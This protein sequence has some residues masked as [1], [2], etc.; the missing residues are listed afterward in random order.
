MATAAPS[1]A[2]GAAVPDA[3]QTPSARRRL[4]RRR[5]PLL[6]GA[7]G[8]LVGLGL[9]VTYTA[10]FSVGYTYFGEGGYF[11]KRQLAWMVVGLV[12][13]AFA[14]GVD[15]RTWRRF[16]TPAMGLTIVAL[17][18]LL[19]FGADRFGS[20]RWVS[21][22]SFQPSELA[23]MALVVYIAHWLAAKKDQLSDASLGLV[24]FS[25]I[26]GLVC[27]LVILQPNF[28]TAVLLAAVAVAM[29]FV[30]G[31]P[32]KH[33]VQ[34]GGVAL[35]L[36]AVVMLQAPYRMARWEV[37]LHPES[38]PTGGGF[39]ILQSIGAI[40]RGGLMGVGLGNGQ[41]KH[42]LPAAHTDGVFAVLAEEMGALGGL[43]VLAMFVIIAWRGLRIATG[44]PDLFGSLLAVGV[45]TWIVLQAVVNMAVVTAVMPFTGIPMPWISFGGSSFVTCTAAVGLLLNISGH[46]DDERAKVTPTMD[47]RWRNSRSRLSRAHRARRLVQ[48]GP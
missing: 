15:Y 2:Y 48:R 8:A 13:G 26:T 20:V 37:F 24:P 3:T 1:R 43:F 18:V 19:A 40:T 30:A 46:I 21:G 4:R 38:D 10:S 29:F 22:G 36:L 17:V 33:L 34:A 31:A 44:A 47:I 23:K 16:A 27:G 28:S 6:L 45:T 5:D 35:G 14:I 41:N 7:V 39:Q 12:A 9:L 25:V 32:L 42:L 11:L